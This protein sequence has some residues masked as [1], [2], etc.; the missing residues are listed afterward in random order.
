M[1]KSGPRGVLWDTRV[2]TNRIALEN[3][4]G[5][6]DTLFQFED[7]ELPD[8]FGILGVGEC[9]SVYVPAVVFL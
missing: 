9:S 1:S 6:W 8:E 5:G 7:D 4:V 3:P 2:I